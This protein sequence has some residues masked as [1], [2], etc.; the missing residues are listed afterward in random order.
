MGIRAVILIFSTMNDYTTFE[1]IKWLNHFGESDIYRINSDENNNII[2]NVHENNFTLYIDGHFI[3]LD[4]L[5]V[6]WYRKGINWIG[7][8][9]K[10]VS[11]NGHPKLTSYLNKKAEKENQK[12]SDYIHYIIEQRIPVLGSAFKYDLN[13][14]IIL[15]M[16]KSVGLYTPEFYILNE[17]QSV[18]NLV[19]YSEQYITK[20]MSD[21]IYLFESEEKRKGYFTYT[22][23]LTRES[24]ENCPEKISPSFIQ[25]KIEK[26]YEVRVFYLDGRFFAWA[27]FSQSDNQ[28]Q[29]DYR[30]YNDQKPNRVVPYILPEEIVKKLSDLFK[31]IG[32]NT[33]SVDLMV[34]L[35][36]NYYF[37]EI[38][39]TGQFSALSKLTNYQLEAEIAR[40]LIDHAKH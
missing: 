10:D 4:E 22:E 20:A 3:E 21:G 24:V 39:P 14:L 30:K 2:F 33:G 28:T 5:S 15:D 19:K 38:N 25:S 12:L 17:K 9:F 40:W 34:D 18:N 27:I 8:Q 35:Q 11:I 37:L 32:L 29:T 1:V 26:Q 7:G 23:L 36:N 13:K 16:A 31:N 6:V